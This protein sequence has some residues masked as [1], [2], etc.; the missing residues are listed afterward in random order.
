MVA[1]RVEP[2][3][4]DQLR[5]SGIKGP[6]VV[7]VVVN[8]DGHVVKAEAKSGPQELY[9]SAEAA[10]RQWKFRPYFLNGTPVEMDTTVTLAFKRK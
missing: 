8:I 4:P 9:A 5:S 2:D 3:Y 10:A 6:V 1:A 7:Q